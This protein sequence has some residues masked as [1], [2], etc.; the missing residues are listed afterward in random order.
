[1]K[2]S[3]FSHFS[4]RS[5]SEACPEHEDTASSLASS[6]LC[7]LVIAAF[8][9]AALSC[10]PD[11]PAPFGALPSKAQVEWQKMETN[12]FVHF[13]PNTF[14]SAEW[15]DGTESADIFA[16]SD[17]DCRQWARTA[18]AAGMKGIIITAKHHDGF[19]LWPN[20]E[21]MHTV[22]YSSWRDGKGDVLKELSEACREYGLKFGVY[23]SPWDRNDPHYGT[24]EYNDIFRKTLESALGNYGDV[25]EQWFDGACGE[26]PSGKRQ[27]YDWDL[28]NSTV[29]KKQPSAVIFSDVGPGC[30]WVGNEYGSAGRTCWGTMNTE[31][32]APG[33]HIDLEVL[34]SGEAGG[35]K[36]VA[37]ETD[38]SIRPG[39][40]WR[41][42]ENGKVKSLHDIMKIYYES[43]GRNSLLLLNVPADTRGHIHETD[44]VRLMEFRA[45]VD[46][47]FAVDLAEGASVEASDERGCRFSAGNILDDD[48][49]SYWT[50][51]DDVLTPSVT[52][53]FDTPRV[54]NRVM[55]QE[56]IPL[57]QRVTDFIVEAMD[58]DGNWNMI[59]RETT[60]GYK[61]ILLIPETEAVALR[62]NISGSF[63]CP[64]LNKVALYLDRISGVTPDAPLWAGD[65][66][67]EDNAEILAASEE[68]VLDLGG[69]TKASG[70]FY[71]PADKGRNGCVITYDLE[72]SI[73]GHE[74][75]KIFSD[76]MFDNIVNNP[77]RQEVRF[78][79]PVELR[80]IRM[81]PLRTS[82]PETYAV[83]DFGILAE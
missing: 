3:D 38:V 82:I 25:F 65:A 50:T 80:Y 64:A 13:G 77:I 83:S 32:R 7:A 23:I 58:T 35:G 11:A 49:D 75:T 5:H 56:Y 24:D 36:W 70:F 61:R 17:L 9:G 16:P 27:V 19:C 40:F 41:E 29:Y 28:F 79:S 52:L 45:A 4:K 44:S 69:K 67:C 53:A 22:A 30:R 60:I 54:F 51:A 55:I 78:A 81:R 8:S 31:G 34:N 39:W 68:K 63:A 71:V 2:I 76:K 73:D 62:I 26:G 66:P 42:S 1:M 57:G 6:L 72:T 15:G 20:P 33:S 48:Y 74:W 59:A 37:P 14:T 43:V 47:I 10:A 12:M 21:S 46:E 18:K